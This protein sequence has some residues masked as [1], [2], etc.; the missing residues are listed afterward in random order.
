MGVSGQERPVGR[1]G[2]LHSS[3]SPHL[4]VNGGGDHYHK[5]AS[6]TGGGGVVY[7]DGSWD[8]SVFV[9]DLQVERTLRV[10]GDLHIG[11]VMIHLVDSLDIAMD[12]SDHAIWW[13]TRNI[14]LDKTRWTLD[15]YNVNA[16]TTI[17]FTPM[18][19]TLR[20]QLPDL[21][22][23]DCTVDFSIKTFNASVTMC[24][25]LGLRHPE[26]LSLC[27]PLDS[28]H[29]KQNYQEVMMRKRPP[30]PTK[31]GS[32]GERLDT[33]TFVSQNG[34]LRSPNSSF[35]T[36]NATLRTPKAARHSPQGTMNNGNYSPY[37][38]G[39]SY[40]P[41]R[42]LSP[43]GPSLDEMS[44]AMSPPATPEAKSS[45]VK[46]RSLEQ[47]ARLNVGWLDSSLSIMEQGVREF[48]TLHLRYKYYNFYD[49][50]PKY[51]GSRINQIYEQ[52]RWQILNE[53]I[54][55]TEEEMML[56][57][58]LQLQVAMQANVP[59]PAADE[60][61]GDD[62]DEELK[63]LEL[64]LEG[65]GGPGWS[66]VTEDP[67][68]ADY[69]QYFKPKRFTLKSYKRL[70][71]V[72]KNL[73]LLAYKSAEAARSNGDLLFSV[74]LK[75]CEVTP[76]VNLSA[77]KYELKLEV[78]SADGMT[79]MHLRFNSEHQYAQWLAAC[80][81]AAKGKTL[82]DS[83]FEM[84]VN[85]IKAFL[86]MQSPAT[87]PA[88]NPNSLEIVAEDYVAP[89]FA[90]KIK[91]KLRQKILE[92][93][94]NVKDLNLVE[95][96]MNFIRA[97]QS[98]PD[99]GVSL[100]VVRFHG[101]KKEELL[102]VAANRVMRMNLQ[103]GDHVK[104]WRYSTMKAWNVNWETRHMMIQFE[105]D[106]NVIFQCL[107]ADCKVIHEFIGGYIFLSMRS[108]D[109]NQQLNQDLFHKLTGGW[110]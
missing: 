78:P 89:R 49:L 2:Q 45:L 91:S 10:R 40:V 107:S 88:I 32:N 64:S 71:F 77:G 6:H 101:E 94:A 102:G 76:A 86:S 58:A 96:K 48:D 79:D 24:R 22:Y 23:I 20:I 17:H 109:S 30:P 12:W 54:D 34:T 53:E 65:G 35:N 16:D 108:K 68:L 8:L 103:T 85:S 7:G 90:R 75:G 52:A 73:Y 81:L 59:Q 72:C 105:D 82:S 63:K 39:H 69:L 83:S 3:S 26:E 95:A 4:G 9:T 66:N 28:E 14:W 31:D 11:G 67:S 43:Q 74:P 97:W 33:N 50:N 41:G 100:F 5:A 47:K 57:A 61:D 98:L 13:P 44:L 93:H 70:F 19:K 56:F 1:S 62:V 92:S 99:Y 104:T 110:V 15:Q 80:R 29:L 46:P 37:S 25:D 60:D 42:P 55:C 18:H 27:K 84:E 36:P 106:K 38:N 51:D 21:R 87:A